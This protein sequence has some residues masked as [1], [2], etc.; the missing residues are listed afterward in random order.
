MF[1]KITQ[2]TKNRGHIIDLPDGLKAMI[3]VVPWSGAT[4]LGANRWQRTA[5]QLGFD[6]FDTSDVAAALD[7]IAERYGVLI[8][9]RRACRSGPARSGVASNS[10]ELACRRLIQTVG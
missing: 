1:G 9:S 5:S 6:T 4:R 7:L 10:S 8:R 2:V 3:N